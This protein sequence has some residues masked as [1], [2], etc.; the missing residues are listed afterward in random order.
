MSKPVTYSNAKKRGYPDFMHVQPDRDTSPAEALQ[1]LSRN[2][3]DGTIKT[4]KNTQIPLLSNEIPR[5]QK[6]Y[7]QPDAMLLGNSLLPLTGSI[8]SNYTTFPLLMTEKLHNV[9]IIGEELAR[10]TTGAVDIDRLSELCIALAAEIREIHLLRGLQIFDPSTDPNTSHLATSM[11]YPV[12]CSIS[13]IDSTIKVNQRINVEDQSDNT[14][15]KRKV[16]HSCELCRTTCTPEWRRGPTGR[17]SLCNACG[18]RYAKR[19]RADMGRHHSLNENCNKKRAIHRKSI[20][21][22]EHMESIETTCN[23]STNASVVSSKK[24]DISSMIN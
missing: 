14:P 20:D 5:F 21:I 9:H 3:I 22:K 19:L 18:L 13:S 8:Y 24:M 7:A 1:M 12:G 6:A 16:E 15:E 17:N 11:R 2:N 23:E 10:T 4:E